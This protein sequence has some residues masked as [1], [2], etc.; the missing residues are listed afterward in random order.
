MALSQAARVTVRMSNGL[1]VNRMYSEFLRAIQ[2]TFQ[3]RLLVLVGRE[4]HQIEHLAQD[5]SCEEQAQA[6]FTL[7]TPQSRMILTRDNVGGSAG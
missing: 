3:G 2:Q 7:P 5:S 4:N 6:G 1:V